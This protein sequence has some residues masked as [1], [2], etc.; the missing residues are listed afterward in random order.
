MDFH[1][2]CGIPMFLADFSTFVFKS[3]AGPPGKLQNINVPI[4]ITRFQHVKRFPWCDK[5][6]GAR[7]NYWCGKN[8]WGRLEPYESIFP[9]W[10]KRC[11]GAGIKNGFPLCWNPFCFPRSGRPE[12]SQAMAARRHPLFFPAAGWSRD[13]RKADYQF[14][15]FIYFLLVLEGFATNMIPH[16]FYKITHL[17]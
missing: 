9:R 10:N 1:Y 13:A 5:T 15:K 7:K 4:G 14:N 16:E 3:L 6:I 17:R 12:P 2:F 8:N 11:H